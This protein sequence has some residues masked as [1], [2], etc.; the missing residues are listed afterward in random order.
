MSE[1]SEPG[2]EGVRVG[3]LSNPKSGSNRR[4]PG[5]LER[6]LQDYPETVHRDASNPGEIRS[7]LLD[8]AHHAPDVLA[9]NGGDGTVQAVLTD[10]LG[11]ETVGWMPQLA[12]LRGGTT[13]MSAADLGPRGRADRAFRRLLEWAQRG[14]TGGRVRRPVLAVRASPQSPS[15]CGLFFGAGAIVKGIEHFHRA[16]NTKGLGG[17]VG[18]GVSMLRMLLAMLRGESRLVAP[19]SMDIELEPASPDGAAFASDYFLVLASSLERLFLGFHPYWGD[20]SGAFHFTSLRAHPVRPLT[21]MPRLLF[22][23]PGPGA[24]PANG[25][26]SRP[27]DGLWLRMD[28]DFTLDGELYSASRRDGP[29]HVR[30]AGSMTFVRL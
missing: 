18:P 4:R 23:K 19:L 6:V 11:D 16:V 29:V 1:G 15:R 13:N 17:E 22:G 30:A 27:V 10:L 24:T 2:R 5:A 21:T 25:Y 26:F 8:L 28:G 9:I 20:G 3:L 12:L 14:A 7:A